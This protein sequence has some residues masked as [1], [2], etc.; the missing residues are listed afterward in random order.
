VTNKLRRSTKLWIG[1]FM[2]I[3][4]YYLI[5]EGAHLIQAVLADN[6][7]YIRFVGIIGIEIMIKEVPTGLELAMFSGLSSVLT[8][9]LGYLLVAIMPKILGLKSKT[10]KVI[11][12]YTTIVFLVLDP[13]YMSILHRFVGGGDMNGVSKGLGISSFPVSLVFGILFII[14]LYI[15]IKKVNPAYKRNFLQ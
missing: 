9:L 2:S 8:I 1:L 11:F 6:F 13:L 14:N 15:A 4:M 7:D 10:M 5:H 12:Y 3:I